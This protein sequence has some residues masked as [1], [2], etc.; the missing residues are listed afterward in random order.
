MDS[1]GI[2][3]A[4]NGDNPFAMFKNLDHYDRFRMV[5]NIVNTLLDEGFDF[6]KTVHGNIDKLLHDERLERSVK[7]FFLRTVMHNLS[8]NERTGINIAYEIANGKR[9]Y[10]GIVE[11]YMGHYPTLKP[12]LKEYHEYNALRH[13]S[14]DLKSLGINMETVIDMLRKEPTQETVAEYDKWLEKN[15]ETD[16]ECDKREANELKYQ[17]WTAEQFLNSYTPTAMFEGLSYYQKLRRMNEITELLYSKDFDISI[18]VINSIR[19]ILFDETIEKSARYWLTRNICYAPSD[20]AVFNIRGRLFSN[21]HEYFMKFIEY[22]KK[23]EE[24]YYRMWLMKT[25]VFDGLEDLIAKIKH[26]E[27]FERFK[28]EQGLIK[29]NCNI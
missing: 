15:V 1:I 21:A 6:N 5:F 9:E 20:S 27:D 3:K 16:K 10:L 2:T 25:E 12:T 7:Y 22:P 18:L 24:E 29:D 19:A 11:R 17:G 13:A 26:H 28:K 4:L 14:C 23:D 8:M